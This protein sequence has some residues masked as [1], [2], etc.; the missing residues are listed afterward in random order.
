RQ[1]FPDGRVV[2][3][4]AAHEEDLFISAISLA[5]IQ[6]GIS[7]LADGKK[8]TPLQQ[9]FDILREKHHG[10]ILDFNEAVALRWGIL[11]ADLLRRGKKMPLEDSYIAAT[12]LVHDLTIAT[13]NEPDF[14]EAGVRIVNPWKE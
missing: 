1:K 13:R 10:A 14:A 8:K 4:L 9:W 7:I 2:D 11:N 6:F 5:E 12:A 3:W